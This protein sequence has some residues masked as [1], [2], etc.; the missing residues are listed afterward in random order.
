MCSIIRDVVRHPFLYDVGKL[1]LSHIINSPQDAHDVPR[2]AAKAAVHRRADR[3]R[4]L[5]FEGL[6]ES[7]GRKIPLYPIQAGE[8]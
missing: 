8:P 4:S 5:I 1:R 3:S 6:R 2:Q 7:G